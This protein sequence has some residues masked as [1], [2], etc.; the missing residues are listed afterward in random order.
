MIHSGKEEYF[1][2]PLSVYDPMAPAYQ[3]LIYSNND[4]V[5]G[6]ELTCGAEQMNQ[7]SYAAARNDHSA[8]AECTTV[9]IALAA[10]SWVVNLLGSVPA[11]ETRLLDIL[12]WVEGKFMEP[13]VLIDF[14][15][16]TTFISPTLAQD[17][18]TTSK[19]ANTVL[20]SFRSWGN[21]GGFDGGVYDVATLLTKRGMTG[22]NGLAYVSAVCK[23]DRYNVVE[24]FVSSNTSLN[25][26][27]IPSII[28]SHEIAHNFSAAHVTGS[29]TYLMLATQ[30]R[31]TV[32]WDP[33]NKTAITNFKTNSS[34]CVGACMVTSLPD[35][36]KPKN[37]HAQV[38]PS[39]AYG[40]ILVHYAGENLTGV[41][42]SLFNAVG[43]LVIQQTVDL[44][45]GAS[46][47]IDVSTLPEGLY[48]LHIQSGSDK[49]VHRVLV[50]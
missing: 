46:S 29:S 1:I 48:L 17:P 30:S 15:L 33:Q 36:M 34:P 18:W 22:F 32:D 20:P 47:A 5:E 13:G 23:T 40:Q 6:S 14:N 9:D 35:N 7:I 16:T 38:Y 42:I 11:T 12:N 21:A 43:G 10:D 44:L 4:I 27:L 19:D 31:Y 26:V 49:T 41:Q 37:L 24:H 2:E 39:P 25:P 8:S 28:M 50:E 45:N 3:Y